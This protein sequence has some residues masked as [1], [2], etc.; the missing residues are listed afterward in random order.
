MFQKS[1]K[2]AVVAT[3]L[4]CSIAVALHLSFDREYFYS[5]GNPPG[6]KSI[7]MSIGPQ[8]EKYLIWNV[9]QWMNSGHNMQGIW[10][11]KMNDDF[12]FVWN[13]RIS[14]DYGDYPAIAVD[15]SG[16]I[17][18][19]WFNN[20]DNGAVLDSSGHELRTLRIPT[21]DDLAKSPVLNID[22]WGDLHLRYL[23]DSSSE[24]TL[25]LDVE[26]NVIDIVDPTSSNYTTTYEL[27]ENL[28]SRSYEGLVDVEGRR[29]VYVVDTDSNTWIVSVNSEAFVTV[30][31]QDGVKL[32]DGHHID[33]IPDSVPLALKYL[34]V[35]APV[36]ISVA[37]II[38][39]A[40]W[41][42]RSRKLE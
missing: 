21:P 27:N 40:L 30:V 37:I 24:E 35:V 18:T 29:P 39:W 7:A 41:L 4:V 16:I 32:V 42:K 17:Y 6:P 9:V 25:I 26:G 38:G 12:D 33:V 8:D 13:K 14:E 23:E 1:T 10:C 2:A 31:N 5:N 22:Q 3:V 19:I 20:H 34:L 28:T 15:S 36:I 11:A